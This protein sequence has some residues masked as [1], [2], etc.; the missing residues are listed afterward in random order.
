[1]DLV[2]H[3]GRSGRLL[4]RDSESHVIVVLKRVYLFSCGSDTSIREFLFV[5]LHTYILTYFIWCLIHSTSTIVQINLQ[6]DN[7]LTF[8]VNYVF[9]LSS[10]QSC[11]CFA[12]IFCNSFKKSKSYK[13]GWWYLCPSSIKEMFVWTV[14]VSFAL[15]SV[16]QSQAAKNLNEVCHL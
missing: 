12:I 10:K 14:Q 8:R 4:E 6:Y 3:P 9:F 1:M 13:Y 5:V 7:F 11:I 2:S 15:G 16:F